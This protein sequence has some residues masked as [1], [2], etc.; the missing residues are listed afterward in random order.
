MKNSMIVRFFRLISQVFSLFV[1]AL[2]ARLLEKAFLTP[3]RRS[4]R[5]AELEV[6]QSAESFQIDFDEQRKLPIYRWGQGPKVLLVHGWSSRAS[7]LTPFVMP[8]VE[9]G[10]Q[11][12]AYDAPAHGAADGGVTGL[13]EMAEAVESLL[14]ELGPM[15][16]VVAH[17][18][19]A[20][21]TTM[22]LS[23]GVN[24]ERVVYLAP[25]YHP[26]RYLRRVAKFF[27]F[28]DSVVRR[29]QKRIETR[30][31]MPFDEVDVPSMVSQ[32]KAPLLVVHD[33][34]DREVPFS[35]G[36]S[37]V[38]SWPKATLRETTGLGHNRILVE[39]KVVAEVVD[40]LSTSD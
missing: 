16:A 27:G 23:R 30:F 32:Q 34:R 21:A 7:Q 35:E 3:S 39:S 8:L 26:G 25:P 6:M 14:A 9:R 31:S 28:S 24:V 17:S 36:E 29:A 10:F 11:V 2:G 13:P 18:L 40:F 4:V 33:R 22:A 5:E 12:Y 20:A 37:L 15:Q 38:R 19:G 1:P